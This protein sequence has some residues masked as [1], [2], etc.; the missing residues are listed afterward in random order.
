MRARVP[1]VVQ[2]HVCPWMCVLLAQK[3]VE[4]R[5]VAQMRGMT[6]SLAGL[7]ALEPAPDLT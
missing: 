4:A 7:M 1:G 6:E 2:V 3:A 5:R